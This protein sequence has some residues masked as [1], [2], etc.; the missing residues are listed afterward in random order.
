L[1][2]FFEKSSKYV[3][4]SIKDKTSKKSWRAKLRI[5]GKEKHL[6]CFKTE[7]AAAKFVNFVCKKESMKIKNPELSDEDTETFTWPLPSKKVAIFLYIFFSIDDFSTLFL[8]ISL[9]KVF[10]NFVFVFPRRMAKCVQKK[11]G[12]F[13]SL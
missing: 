1:T 6:G 12:L 2:Y 9:T 13:L 5:D 11:S 10:W 7:I 3:G 8:F 4:V